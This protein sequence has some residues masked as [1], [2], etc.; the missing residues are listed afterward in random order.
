MDRTYV[1]NQ[2]LLGTDKVISLYLAISYHSHWGQFSSSTWFRRLVENSSQ[3]FW[4]F[5]DLPSAGTWKFRFSNGGGTSWFSGVPFDFDSFDATSLLQKKSTSS[6]YS[7]W[8]GSGGIFALLWSRSWIGT[9]LCLA[10]VLSIPPWISASNSF[11]ASSRHNV[12]CL[13]DRPSTWG[14]PMF[15]LKKSSSKDFVGFDVERG[16]LQ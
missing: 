3:L 11:N 10:W 2:K 7:R 4:L 1:R 12:K 15:V 13:G 8:D 5:P 14:A 9:E 6:A 16:F